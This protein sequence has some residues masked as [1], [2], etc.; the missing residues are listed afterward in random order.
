MNLKNMSAGTVGAML[1][2]LLGLARTAAAIEGPQL[3]LISSPAGRPSVQ[4]VAETQVVYKVLTCPDL[5]GPWTA[6]Y[7]RVYST[8]NGLL[9]RSPRAYAP[10]MMY[11]VAAQTLNT[12]A[13]EVFQLL[14]DYEWPSEAD[15]AGQQERGFRYY[16]RLAADRG[17]MGDGLEYHAL[18]VVNNCLHAVAT[19]GGQGT[20][21]VGRW[22]SLQ[23]TALEV[24]DANVISFTAPLP[25][26]IAHRWQMPITA[27]SFRARGT[28][29]GKLE[30]KDRHNQLLRV[31]PFSTS[32]ANWQTIR[33]NVDPTGLNQAKLLNLIIESPSDV[34]IDDLGMVL[35]VP[36]WL[37]DDPLL[38]AMVT[39]YAALLRAYDPIT[40][41]TRDHGHWP[42]GDF[43]TIPGCGFQALAAAFAADLGIISL[44]DARQIAQRSIAAML[45]A[46]RYRGLL[47]HWMADGSPLDY[48]TVDSALALI[49]G[50]IA[51]RILDLPAE[52]NSL[53]QVIDGIEWTPLI[54]AQNRVSHGYT[55]DGSVSPYTWTGFGGE[56]ALVQILR[57]LQDPTA[58]LFAVDAQPPV[59]GGR[60][61][62]AEIAALLIPQLGFDNVA[63]RLGVNWRQMRVSMLADQKAYFAAH[64]PGSLAAVLGLYGLSAVEIRDPDANTFYFNG[65]V[66]DNTLPADDGGGWIAPHYGAMVAALDIDGTELLMKHF[67]DLGILQP[68]IGLPEAVFAGNAGAAPADWHSVQV[69]LNTSLSLIGLYH[70]TRERDGGPD[71]I[72]DT[73]RSCPRLVAAIQPMVP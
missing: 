41:R 14:D 63:D 12:N 10:V 58:T 65:G 1:G 29:H 71:V 61:F 42:A 21:W 56:S 45:A 24:G 9:S 43:D 64:N 27:L 28:G 67:Q 66:G 59:Y 36:R 47:P 17:D 49:T 26:P 16:G 54:D 72:Y 3:T 4:W 20:S 25:A 53:L 40:G 30:I 39:T 57:L 46:P 68:M 31:Y 33:V 73:V 62:I 51:C 23:H 60:G 70:G 69:S 22:H 18:S 13:F 15:P 48:S 50:L 6:A 32:S 2:L 5:R 52:E 38:Y 55:K 44:N 34:Y 7:T 19:S 37:W 11:A 8:T 35:A